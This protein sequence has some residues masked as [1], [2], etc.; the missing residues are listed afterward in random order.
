MKGGGLFFH[1]EVLLKLYT[2]R[3]VYVCLVMGRYINTDM[4]FI[5]TVQAVERYNFPEWPALPDLCY[6]ELQGELGRICLMCCIMRVRFF[7]VQK[8]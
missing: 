3:D 2:Q 1:Q 6:V 7:C 4:T 5:Y 8:D